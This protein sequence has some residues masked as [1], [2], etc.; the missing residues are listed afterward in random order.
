VSGQSNVESGSE[1]EH[2]APQGAGEEMAEE[3]GFCWVCGAAVDERHC[4]IVCPRCGFMR[5]CSDP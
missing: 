1:G 4:K 3:R 5:D 2:T